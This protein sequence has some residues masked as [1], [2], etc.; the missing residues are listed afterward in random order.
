MKRPPSGEIIQEHGT[1]NRLAQALGSQSSRF[2]SGKAEL[3][4][5]KACEASPPHA[6]ELSLKAYFTRLRVVFC[7]PLSI[8]FGGRPR[9]GRGAWLREERVVR[10]FVDDK[11]I[12]WI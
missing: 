4:H 10:Q 2:V 12:A 7:G 6:L 3:G 11:A 8:E 1:Q 5:A 9:R